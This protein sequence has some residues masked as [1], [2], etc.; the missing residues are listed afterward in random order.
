M[1]Q[2]AQVNEKSARCQP[3]NIEKDFATPNFGHRL[4]RVVRESGNPSVH[5]APPQH[6]APAVA[7]GARQRWMV[8]AH[9]FVI[10]KLRLEL[11]V[12]KCRRMLLAGVDEVN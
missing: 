7:F 8:C 4:I 2:I 5:F 9:H 11:P 6:R 12:L 3:K 1:V 10:A